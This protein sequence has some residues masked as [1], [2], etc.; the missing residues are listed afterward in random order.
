MLIQFAFHT[1][2]SF[3]NIEQYENIRKIDFNYILALPL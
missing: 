3:L 2:T 1:I